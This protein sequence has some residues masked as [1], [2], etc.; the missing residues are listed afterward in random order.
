MS[1][2]PADHLLGAW[3]EGLRGWR[4]PGWDPGVCITACAHRQCETGAGD[5]QRAGLEREPSAGIYPIS[6]TSRNG[7]PSR[8][9]R[10]TRPGCWC[11]TPP[12]SL[13]QGL[14]DRRS[15]A[16]GWPRS[17]WSRPGCRPG[18][19]TGRCRCS[20]PWACR[21]TPPLPY[22]WTWGRALHSDGRAR[23]SA[24]AHRGPARAGAGAGAPGNHGSV[25]HDAGADAGAAADPL[26]AAIRTGFRRQAA[27]HVRAVV[28][29]RHQRPGQC[30]RLAGQAGGAGAAARD[31]GVDMAAAG[32]QH[33]GSL[34][35]PPAAPACRPWPVARNLHPGHRAI[36]AFRQ[37]AA[38]PQ[39]DRLLLGL[40]R[41]VPAGI[42]SRLASAIAAAA[43][44]AAGWRRPPA[45]RPRPRP[46]RRGTRSP[47][48]SSG[49]SSAARRRTCLRWPALQP[50]VLVPLSAISSGQ[51]RQHPRA[52][53]R[54]DHFR[55]SFWC[56]GASCC[57]PSSSSGAV[58]IARCRS[59]RA[60]GAGGPSAVPAAA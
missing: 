42:A 60:G 52:A 17:R 23:R 22:F 33:H 31:L 37:Q 13:D 1:V 49:C 57:S 29:R 59:S 16:R 44:R 24:P 36:L 50:A 21:R 27:L 15:C 19:W 6:P 3:G 41:R 55:C 10:S 32:D 20:A 35:A 47:T 25:L 30:H 40:E 39:P 9:S 46:S 58:A 8:A 4:R 18:W 5:D 26:R 12:W 11:C 38:V 56:S 14:A 28:T 7:S 48:A 45:P 53:R 51:C 54:F 34:P 2:V 43:V